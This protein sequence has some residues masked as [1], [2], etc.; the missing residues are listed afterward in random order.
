M[1]SLAKLTRPRFYAAF[2]RERLFALLDSYRRCPVI[3]IAGPPGAGKTTLIA[4]W[5]DARA[6]PGLWYQVDDGD[7]DPA[8]FF[9][10]LREAA[11][12]IA[13]RRRTPLPLLTSEY[14]P[15]LP[16][17]ARHWFRDLFTRLPGPSHWCW[18]IIR[19]WRRTRPFT[20]SLRWLPVRCPKMR[21]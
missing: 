20:G 12:P 4:T 7:A 5:L 14:L 18:T 6:P 13:A 11:A 15:D 10:Y 17:F 2:P 9:Y 21:I 3:W 19:K 16:G 1:T 8:T